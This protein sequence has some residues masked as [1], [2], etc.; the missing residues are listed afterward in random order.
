MGSQCEFPEP[1]E[2][3]VTA[4]RRHHHGLRFYCT[5]N[6]VHKGASLTAYILLSELEEFYKEHGFYPEELYIQLDGGSE[7]AN[8]TVLALLELLVV[9][10]VL[11]LVSFISFCRYYIC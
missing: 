5:H 8:Q 7:N 11:R 3:H 10:K 2:Q 1:L 6:T 4:V 9:K